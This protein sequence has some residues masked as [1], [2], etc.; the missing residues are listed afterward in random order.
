MI[1]SFGEEKRA[2]MLS[3][4]AVDFKEMLI[5]WSVFASPISNEPTAKKLLNFALNALRFSFSSI[6]LKNPWN[7]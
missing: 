1:L 3:A 6:F 2:Q 4:F 5:P 7:F